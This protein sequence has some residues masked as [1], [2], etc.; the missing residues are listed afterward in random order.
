MHFWMA[1]GVG[2]LIG[3]LLGLGYTIIAIRRG[4]KR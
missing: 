1:F 2:V 3:C 4:N